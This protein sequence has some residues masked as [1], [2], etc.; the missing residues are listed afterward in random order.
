MSKNFQ[1]I[2]HEMEKIANGIKNVNVNI[3]LINII[4]HILLCYTTRVEC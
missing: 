4:N 2:F 1:N 3:F